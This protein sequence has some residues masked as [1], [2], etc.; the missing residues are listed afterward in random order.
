MRIT[1]YTEEAASWRWSSHILGKRLLTK[2][3][4]NYNNLSKTLREPE[5]R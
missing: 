1:T 3:N 5:L 2:N 4:G